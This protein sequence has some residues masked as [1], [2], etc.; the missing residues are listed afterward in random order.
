MVP[1]TWVLGLLLLVLG[2]LFGA[3]LAMLIMPMLWGTWSPAAFWNRLVPPSGPRDFRTLVT[4]AKG[5][6]SGSVTLPA[7]FAKA[8]HASAAGTLGP[9]VTLAGNTLVFKDC[10]AHP[11][12]NK[13][14]ANVMLWGTINGTPADP[15]V[16]V[17]VVAN[18]SREAE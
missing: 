7:A 18:G 2:C 17:R 14:D 3:S 1:I 16:N 5:K 4:C 9:C 13:A 8:A 10:S 12:A 6:C 15:A 11:A